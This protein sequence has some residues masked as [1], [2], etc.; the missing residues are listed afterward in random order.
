MADPKNTSVS[1][2]APRHVPSSGPTSMASS[3]TSSMATLTRTMDIG[4]FCMQQF[5]QQK[6]AAVL[7]QP[8]HLTRV[9][10][11]LLMPVVCVL[12]SMGAAICILIFTRKQMRSSL[13]IYLAGL[14]IFDLVLLLMSLLIY[15][16]MNL[17][18]QEGHQG[19]VCHFF[20]RTSLA[21]YPISLM[22]QTGSVWTCVAITVDRFLAVK[23]PLHTRA[24]CTSHRA[25]TVLNCIGVVAILYKM[26]S[27]FELSLDECGRLRPTELR[28]HVLYIIIYNTY[29]YLL[30]L[31]V[32]PFL[33][34]I[35]LNIYIV[36]A[37]RDANIRRRRM[38]QLQQR[39]SNQNGAGSS[40]TS[41]HNQFASHHMALTNQA[42]ESTGGVSVVAPLQNEKTSC[43]RH[44][45][46]II[47]SHGG[48]G[49]GA[50]NATERPSEK[51]ASYTSDYDSR[52]TKMATVT[53]VAFVMFNWLAGMNNV[54]EA[55]DMNVPG[56]AYRI[57]I[58]NLLVC[59]NSATNIL[60]YSIFG[61]RFRKMCAALLCPCWRRKYDPLSRSC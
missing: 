30:L 32:I 19:P 36:N 26:P 59:L 42:S 55:F 16:S 49:H 44:G 17:C 41:N 10:Y 13:S 28:N 34:I 40:T 47:S 57:P 52:C 29:G 1:A 31:L 38:Q 22:A 60:I 27:I 54:I 25:R 15:P 35:A 8:D 24:W 50:N 43:Y 23:Y 3:A 6:A 33:I 39:R 61:R 14:S 20:W 7:T 46:S 2:M 4:L 11:T 18:L 21:T 58:G 45:G 48:S 37:V 5:Q 53:I 51:T 9:I 56:N 12:G